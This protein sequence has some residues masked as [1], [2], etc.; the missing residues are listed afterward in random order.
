MLAAK[1][2]QAAKPAVSELFQALN[3]VEHSKDE[4]GTNTTMT[5]L[6]ETTF[7]RR[8]KLPR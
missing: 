5:G 7:V 3:A 6:L 8:V 1:Q 4:G 2:E